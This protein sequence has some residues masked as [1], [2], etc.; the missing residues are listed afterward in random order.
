MAPCEAEHVDTGDARGFP[1]EGPQI[2]AGV[3]HVI[4]RDLSAPESG[5][6]VPLLPLCSMPL[7]QMES[8]PEW[9]DL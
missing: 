7:P 8:N 6:L 3:L 1:A 2:V 4:L 5:I 9:G